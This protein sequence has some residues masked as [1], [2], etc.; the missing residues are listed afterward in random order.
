ME[1]LSA[2]ALDN[3]NQCRGSRKHPGANNACATPSVG[4]FDEGQPQAEAIAID[5]N[6]IRAVGSTAAMSRH[7][8]DGTQV[9]DLNGRLVVPGFVEAHGHFTAIGLMRLDLDLG[10]ADSHV[11]D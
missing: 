9:I 10:A 8:G 7:I 1:I 11:H 5:G 2:C 3:V 6:R 4:R